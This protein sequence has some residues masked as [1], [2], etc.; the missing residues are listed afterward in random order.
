MGSLKTSSVESSNL[1][2]GCSTDGIPHL[3]AIIR[4][5][6]KENDADTYSDSLQHTLKQRPTYWRPPYLAASK[7][8][9]PAW[10]T[11]REPSFDRID[12]KDG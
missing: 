12:Q 6:H 9:V 10:L 5:A 1:L 7:V 8:S 2:C 4:E 11:T 3:R